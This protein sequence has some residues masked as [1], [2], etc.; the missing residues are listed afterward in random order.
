MFAIIKTYKSVF[1]GLIRNEF[2]ETM[3]NS[4]IT[5]DQNNSDLDE[6]FQELVKDW[7]IDEKDLKILND[8]K[9]DISQLEKQTQDS[10]KKYLRAV[11]SSVLENWFTIKWQDGLDAL[12]RIAEMTS[13][14]NL[15]E[16]L[17]KITISDLDGKT[18]AV[19]GDKVIVY[20]EWTREWFLNKDWVDI[21]SSPFDR[22]STGNDNVIDLDT[23]NIDSY[24]DGLIKNNE[25]FVTSNKNEADQKAAREVINKEVWMALKEMFILLKTDISTLNGSELNVLITKL[26]DSK[27]TFN[28][29]IN[30]HPG[31]K[32]AFVPK[33]DAKILEVNV[34]KEVIRQIL[35]EKKNVW[36]EVYNTLKLKTEFNSSLMI[37]L[38]NVN[39]K[40]KWRGEEILK[41]WK[42]SET[43]KDNYINEINASKTINELIII[44]TNTSKFMKVLSQMGVPKSD[45]DSYSKDIFA[46]LV[47]KE[48]EFRKAEVIRQQIE[49][50]QLEKQD[51]SN[52]IAWNKEHY[53]KDWIKLIQEA[54]IAK[55]I[56][57]ATYV[58]RN[59]ETVSSA[60]GL[61]WKGTL[62]AVKKVWITDWK[63]WLSGLKTLGLVDSNNKAVTWLTDEMI[64]QGNWNLNNITFEVEEVI[65]VNNVQ[66]TQEV[67]TDKPVGKFTLNEW[68]DFSTLAD[69]D[70][71]E[72]GT[73]TW[74]D[75]KE[76]KVFIT[77]H[78]TDL[79]I[80][81]GK[82]GVINQYDESFTEIEVNEIKDKIQTT[83]DSYLSDDE[84]FVEQKLKLS[85]SK[86]EQL[87]AK[88]INTKEIKD[89]KVRFDI[90]NNYGVKELFYDLEEKVIS[91]DNSDKIGDIDLWDKDL[92]ETLLSIDATLKLL[93]KAEGKAYDVAN[94]GS[95][96]VANQEIAN[97]LENKNN[98]G[99]GFPLDSISSVM[100]AKAT[101]EDGDLLLSDS[102]KK[103]KEGY[104]MIWIDK[105]KME[106]FTKSVDSNFQ[107]K[108]TE[109]W[110][111]RID[112]PGSNDVNIEMKDGQFNITDDDNKIDISVSSV[113]IEWLKAVDTV[114]KAF[115][116]LS[117]RE[118]EDDYED[119]TFDKYLNSLSKIETTGELLRVSTL[120]ENGGE[121]VNLNKIIE[122]NEKEVKQK[123]FD[124]ELKDRDLEWITLS[125]SDINELSKE[126]WVEIDLSNIKVMNTIFSYNNET[127][128]ATRI[129]WKYAID[130]SGWNNLII[131]QKNNKFIIT[132]TDET[133]K[134]E[135]NKFIITDT[136]E[137]FKIED[138][139]TLKDAIIAWGKKV[140]KKED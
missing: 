6:K 29:N 69:G 52:D 129:G 14:T 136:D 80:T 113:E 98:E 131:E 61:F 21:A 2:A 133:F 73:F 54:L 48:W 119:T 86:K 76:H 57:K 5:P 53:S 94:D 104:R 82:T 81:L 28:T 64:N 62:S 26:N 77:K 13:N 39:Q 72:V 8:I 75:G 42:L 56:L 70:N 90:D 9:A 99:I 46:A 51:V 118:S 63:I 71:M 139:R 24:I 84:K 91:S 34:E 19:E 30:I 25:S 44:K 50:K 49:Q 32:K 125:I 115:D 126:D 66:D 106:T 127:H 124:K 89:G 43:I 74:K 27:I 87:T 105:D 140:H 15:S 16:K 59:W 85:D 93:S 68:I 58:N 65:T 3:R 67:I 41:V 4:S 100:I 101:L 10:L 17:S 97:I 130:I 88:W 110:I 47:I 1:T 7:K 122:K 120:I 116:D 134:I 137:T 78:E 36:V 33:I 103:E 22:N 95:T 23:A 37:K 40:L 60:D 11:T 35:E 111:F 138:N 20:N 132:D 38:K 128:E 117:S 18:I 121:W 55:W 31:H 107:V 114:L 108:D 135:D 96:V 79:N 123:E 102:D 92:T 45:I 112:R 109:K 12:K 83:I